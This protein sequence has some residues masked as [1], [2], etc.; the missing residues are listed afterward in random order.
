MSSKGVGFLYLQT[1]F[2]TQQV[3]VGGCLA[4]FESAEDLIGVV[5]V[6]VV[7]D[8]HNDN[9]GD[10]VEEET[11][12]CYVGNDIEQVNQYQKY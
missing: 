10:G 3:C 2:D 9:N 7:V 11:L 8:N 6:V 1:L 12:V 4:T 5:V